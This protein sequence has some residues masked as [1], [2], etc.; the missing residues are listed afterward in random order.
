[1]ELFRV[2]VL[3]FRLENF[4]MEMRLC[5]NVGELAMG[6][7]NEG[8]AVHFET[9][10]YPEFEFLLILLVALS[11]AYRQ[12][13]SCP[14]PQPKLTKR[15]FFASPERQDF[16]ALVPQSPLPFFRLRLERLLAD[17]LATRGKFAYGFLAVLHYPVAMILLPGSLLEMR[18]DSLQ[19]PVEMA[20][21]LQL[22]KLPDRPPAVAKPDLKAF[23]PS[24]QCFDEFPALPWAQ[25]APGLANAL[26]TRSEKAKDC[27]GLI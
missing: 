22:G 27:W 25:V 13:P 15:D 16:A 19:F 24:F 17:A 11:C 5:R 14:L 6:V 12:P 7:S 10:D 1:M 18:W 23:P 4:E 20:N 8:F 2:V 9:W 26:W 3:Q 21:A